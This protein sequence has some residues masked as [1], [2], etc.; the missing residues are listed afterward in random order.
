[1]TPPRRVEKA[2]LIGLDC[3]V[4]GRWRKYAEA[5]LLPVGQRLL[6]DGCFAA[7][8]LPTMPTLTTTNWATI[9]TGA[10]PG[11]HGVTDFN[12][13]RLGDGCD[14]S[15]Q[16]FDAREVRAEFVWE[17][18]VRAGRDSIVVNWPGSWPPR[19]APV[20]GG[21]GGA[22]GGGSAGAQVPGR[23]V[24][25]AKSW[26]SHPAVDRLAPILPWGAPADVPKVSPVEASAS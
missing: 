24:T 19:E 13:Y 3:A 14:D 20:A 21:T 2:L 4:P 1:M 7:Q 17:A 23:L 8:C 18:V 11:T 25:S 12:P 15:P 6:A 9:A 10:Y 5:G 16:G 26:L 22:V